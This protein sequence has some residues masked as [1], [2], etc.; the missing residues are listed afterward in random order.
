MPDDKTITHNSNDLLS[1]LTTIQ[2]S[3]QNIIPLQ[4]LIGIP[5]HNTIS[6]QPIITTLKGIDSVDI[7]FKFDGNKTVILSTT[8]NSVQVFFKVEF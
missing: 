6:I 7:S 5:D 8:D 4:L 1:T 2:D 3:G